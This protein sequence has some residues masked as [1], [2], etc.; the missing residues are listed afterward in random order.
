M[1]DSAVKK[2]VL[3]LFF[4]GIMVCGLASAG[5]AHCAS[6]T[7][8]A[9]SASNVSSIMWSIAWNR[10]YVGSD[11]LE[12]DSVIQTVDGGFL[13]GG[14]TSTSHGEPTKI[15]LVKVD[16]SGN[17]QWNKTYEGI[18]NHYSKWLIQTSDGGYALAG[19]YAGSFWLAKIDEAGN[20]LWNQTYNGAGLS[21][22]TSLTETN[23][24]G[25][26]LTGQ[27]NFSLTEGANS[28]SGN[29]VV[30]LVKTDALGNEQWNTT[31]GEG[32]V[33]SI[34]Q[35]NDGGYVLAGS[36]NNT[37]D[38]LLMKTNSNG[39]YQWSET[40]G[41]QDDDVCYS[42]VQTAD[43]GYALG[44]WM[45][46]RSNGGGP[47]IAIVK[48]DALGNAQWTNCYGE[49]EARSM[50]QTSD[51]GFAAVGDKFI[52]VDAVGNEQWEKSF[53]ESNTTNYE[54]YSVIQTQ[55]GGYAI[56]GASWATEG[57][58]ITYAWLAKISSTSSTPSPKPS[59]SPAS[60]IPEASSWMMFV[61]LTVATA[62]FVTI[63][64]R[65]R[66]LRFKMPLEIVLLFLA[67]FIIMCLVLNGT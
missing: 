66:F 32:A 11:L 41:N 33:N 58:P 23:D 48:T 21:W 6:G 52:K 12:V 15:E 28:A 46:L 29:G 45:W 1:V 27:T 67:S 51:G 17:L 53:G 24:G 4:I 35:T 36:I 20:M 14:T 37:P 8:S 49:G 34:I 39:D 65:T 13:L 57:N 19:E 30:W 61:L 38:Y 22:A 59:N 63:R 47:N 64:K 50:V 40:Y 25:Y 55:D 54:A 60:S 5:N 44:G 10:T 62:L 56:A 31:L 9:S 43:G 7:S 2:Q 18:G 16:S 3:S 26:A 42:V